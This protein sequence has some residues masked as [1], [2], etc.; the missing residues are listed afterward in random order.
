M[1]HISIGDASGLL[2][3][4]DD[5][6]SEIALEARNAFWILTKDLFIEI[7]EELDK[8]NWDLSSLFFECTKQLCD[9]FL[10]LW[11]SPVLKNGDAFLD[12]QF[13][14]VVR[15]CVDHFQAECD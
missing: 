8:V 1:K 14:V 6:K 4:F 11:Y 12:E 10:V 15:I 5:L 2:D 7:V 13:T 9:F 3:F